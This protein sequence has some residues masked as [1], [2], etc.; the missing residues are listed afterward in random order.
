MIERI[1]VSTE[2]EKDMHR[3]LH[4]NVILIILVTLTA[5]GKLSFE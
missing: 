1:T 3:V 2:V 5:N 4:G